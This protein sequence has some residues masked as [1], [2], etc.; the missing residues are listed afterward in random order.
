[1]ELRKVF[2]ITYEDKP[3]E[4]EGD[5]GHEVSWRTTFLWDSY[6]AR[7]ASWDDQQCRTMA[8]RYNVVVFGFGSWPASY[9]QYSYGEVLRRADAF[10]VVAQCLRVNGVTV[11]YAGTPAWPKH[12]KKN[13]GFRI[14]NTR[15]SIY[16]R[17]AAHALVHAKPPTTPPQNIALAPLHFLPLYDLSIS[18]AVM[19]RSDGMHYDGSVV[20]FGAIEIL[21]LEL[22]R[23]CD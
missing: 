23:L 13:P 14:T 7:L 21:A 11:V 15:L 17:M 6:L 20:T 12:R 19:K 4:D 8:L 16:N 1:V 18:M 9:G 2:N 10:A 22:L 5:A 3:E